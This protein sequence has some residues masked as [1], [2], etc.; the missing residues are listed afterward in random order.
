MTSIQPKIAADILQS[1]RLLELA[2]TRTLPAFASAPEARRIM[3]VRT[4]A[5]ERELLCD[6]RRTYGAAP[7]PDRS[8]DGMLDLRTAVVELS[9]AYSG[10]QRVGATGPSKRTLTDWIKAGACIAVPLVARGDEAARVMVGRSRTAN[11]ALR[12]TSVSKIHAY[13]EPAERNTLHVTD[14]GSRNGTFVN[15]TRIASSTRVEVRLGDR[16]RFGQV[17]TLLCPAEVFWHA[18]Q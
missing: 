12:S 2:R 14:P 4:P 8:S 13:F 18:A 10:L 6:L 16:V 5:A 11:L 3:L 9:D 17:E 7:V 1:S 15:G